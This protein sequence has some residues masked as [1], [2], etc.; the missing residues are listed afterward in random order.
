MEFLTE[1]FLAF[2]T[3]YWTL[4]AASFLAATILPFS[5]EII[6]GYLLTQNASVPMT[7]FAATSGNVL[8]S[9]TNYGVGM[10]GS[11]V[12][13]NKVFGMSDQKVEIA[14]D[15]FRRYGTA[16]LLFAWVPVI[17]DPLT[18]VAG[19]L[20]IDFSLFLLLVGGG[21]FLRYVAVIFFLI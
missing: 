17:G 5:S 2:G 6:M 15:R 19:I 18:I 20:K 16:S 3:S 4:F 21:K 14:K 9:V 13:L 12:V 1:Y 11:R 10:L 8:G 7:L